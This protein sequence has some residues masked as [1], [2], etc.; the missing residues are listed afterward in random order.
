MNPRSQTCGSLKVFATSDQLKLSSW[1]SLPIAPPA[2]SCASTYSFSW[3]FKKRAW[4]GERGR[5]KNDRSPK[6][7][8]K[9]PSMMKIHAHAGRPALPFRLVVSAPASS[10]VNAPAR[11]DEEKNTEIL[12][13]HDEIG[14]NGNAEV[15]LHTVIEA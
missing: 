9:T 7:T 6:P 2:R 1:T 12:L 5:R 4:A 3:A 13:K 10:P 15:V 8:V 11:D 14:G